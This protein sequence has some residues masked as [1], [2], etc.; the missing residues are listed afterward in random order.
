MTSNPSVSLKLSRLHD[1][2]MDM[3]ATLREPD[4]GNFAEAIRYVDSGIAALKNDPTDTARAV[5]LCERARPLIAITQ[6][7][8][9]SMGGRVET[10]AQ[11]NERASR[12]LRE[13]LAA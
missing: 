7:T 11:K 8:Y 2:L 4:R 3:K 10:A 12:L 6:A 13:I 5:G 1:L 9:T